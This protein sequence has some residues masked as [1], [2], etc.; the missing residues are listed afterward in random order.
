MIQ[1]CYPIIFSARSNCGLVRRQNEDVWAVQGN[2]FVLADGMGGHNAGE[3]A[4]QMAVSSLVEAFGSFDQQASR[5][6]V[7]NFCKKALIEVNLKVSEAGNAHAEWKGMGSTLSALFFIDKLVAVMH[8]GDS[9]IYRLRKNT[10]KQL[11]VDHTVMNRMK[12]VQ[13]AVLFKHVL[14]RAIGTQREI[15]PQVETFP[16]HPQDRYLICSDGL[17]NY[18]SDEEIKQ[19]MADTKDLEAT[20]KDMVQ[21]ALDR[22]G[23]DN[24]TLILIE[25][26]S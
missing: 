9:R 8:V 1:T 22:G 25:V 2:L 15:R 12:G 17:S 18:L 3:V 10:L 4:A 19:K 21:L 26:G 6:V 5:E 16:V 13:E 7:K 20:S 24:I 23:A 11:T 14:T